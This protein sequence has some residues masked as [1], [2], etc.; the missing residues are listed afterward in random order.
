MSAGRVI[1]G[2]LIAFLGV[3]FLGTN[4]GWWDI[5]LWYSLWI[6]WPIVLIAAGIG[7]LFRSGVVT[8]LTLL[9]LGGLAVWALTNGRITT[10]GTSPIFSNWTN[11]DRATFSQ[12]LTTPNVSSVV[13]D[14]GGHMDVTIQTGR[15]EEQ[16]VSA[17]FSGPQSVIEGFS[18]SQVNNVVTLQSRMG[19]GLQFFGP[20]SGRV[21]GTITVPRSVPLD[22]RSN[23]AISTEV[24]GHEGKVTLRS[25]GGSSV[26]FQSSVTR[27]SILD[28]S[29]AANVRLDRCEDTLRAELSGASR[30]SA[31]TCTVT[32]A[33]IRASGGSAVDFSGA[34]ADLTVEASG[35]SRIKVPRPTG[36]NDVTTSGA[37]SVS[38]YE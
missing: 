11:Q 36:R 38:Y 17:L 1:L 10:S 28:L 35:A 9:V 2:F 6:L 31:D 34:L 12:S 27:D 3:L 29:G 26:R 19:D 8:L 16:V 32:T 30:L 13:V 37:G 18:L 24:N 4:L 25:S 7:L 23:G 21:E 5:T 15:A 14:L 33:A 20:A 22:I